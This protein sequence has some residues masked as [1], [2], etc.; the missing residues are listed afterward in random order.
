MSLE[1]VVKD[2]DYDTLKSAYEIFKKLSTC[3]SC[4]SKDNYCGFAPGLGEPVRYN[5]PFFLR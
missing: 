1:E 4:K 3:N 2:V 5:C